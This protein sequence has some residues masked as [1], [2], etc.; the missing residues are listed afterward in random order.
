MRVVYSPPRSVG[1]Y[2]GEIDNWSWPRHTGDFTLLRVYAGPD[3]QPAPKGDANVPYHPRHFFPV[4]PEGVQPGAFVMLAGYPG[5]TV[6]SLIEPEMRERAE[7]YHPRRAE[8][9]RRL[10]RPHG[11]GLQ[12]RTTS[13]A[14]PSP[15]A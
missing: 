13:P 11:G 5:L 8:L 10:D 9:Y 7:L 3:N 2:G 4:S 1:E 6:R 15:T 14:S 12:R